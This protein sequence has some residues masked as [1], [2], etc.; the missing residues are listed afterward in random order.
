MKQ[1]PASVIIEKN[2]IATGSAWLLFIDI[3]ITP[4]IVLHFVRNTEAV[5][6]KGINYEAF[7]FEL[8]TVNETTK[9]EIPTL[10][11]RVSNVTR[12]IQTY[13]EQYQGG[14]G[15]TVKLM[16]VNSA[17]LAEDFSDLEMEFDI[18]ETT[19]DVQW[20]SFKLG[21]P[22]PLRQRF[23]KSRYF[24]SYCRWVFK[25]AGCG[26]AGT[27]TACNKR[28]LD[29]QALNNSPRFGGFPGLSERGLR[30]AY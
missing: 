16:V 11:L 22:N 3:T 27:A 17:Y 7:P 18:L 21:A 19:S 23:P 30:V 2:K 9:G 24:S 10:Q 4:E 15:K 28:L 1:L 5:E 29:C 14:I 26:Y 8:D 25:D 6:Y 13:L 20:V 12:I